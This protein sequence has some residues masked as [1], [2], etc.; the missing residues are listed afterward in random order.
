MDG[1][2]ESSGRKMKTTV[3]EQQLKNKYVI[4]DKNKLKK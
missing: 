1:A 2:G 4:K 3:L